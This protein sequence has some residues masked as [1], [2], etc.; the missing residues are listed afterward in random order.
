MQDMSYTVAKTLPLRT[1]RSKYYMPTE[2]RK[3][4]KFHGTNEIFGIKIT[5][6][7][8]IS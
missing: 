3:R 1:T 2:C 7:T 5:A 8:A 6:G 4:V